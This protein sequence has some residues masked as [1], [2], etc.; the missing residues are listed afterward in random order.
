MSSLCGSAET[1]PAS[2]HED[3]GFITGLAQ[4]VNDLVLPR[5]VV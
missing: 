1:N 4:W 5:G 3:A 2:V